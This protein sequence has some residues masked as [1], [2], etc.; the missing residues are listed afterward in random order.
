MDPHEL[1]ADSATPMQAVHAGVVAYGT[2][3][4]WQRD[5]VSRRAADQIG[6]TVLT[7]EHP[8]VYT[9]GKRAS[10]DNVLL[11]D[12]ELAARGIETYDVDRGGDVTY[13]GPGQLVAYPILRLRHSKAIVPYVRALEEVGMRVAASYGIDAR[14]VEGASGAWVGDDKLMAIGVRV[15]ADRVTEHG[16]A[17][18]VTTDLADF[19]GIVPCGITDKG[20]CSLRS[21][22]VDTTVEEAVGRLRTAFAEVFGA[23]V[24]DG[25]SLDLLPSRA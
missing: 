2:A 21:L 25:A 22:G 8:R 24:E 15:T 4:E 23:A 3:W 9:L 1:R 19:G 7:L 13:H 20:V 17:I 16:L 18:N 10:R 11:S 6:D 12:T 5:L 14:R